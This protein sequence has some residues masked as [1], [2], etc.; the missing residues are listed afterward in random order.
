MSSMC[1]ESL[2]DLEHGMFYLFIFYSTL[3]VIQ[4]VRLL[5]GENQNNVTSFLVHVPRTDVSFQTNR[6]AVVTDR[7]FSHVHTHPPP[8]PTPLG[9][10]VLGLQAAA[11]TPFC[12]P[13]CR[14]RRKSVTHPSTLIQPGI[15]N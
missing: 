3:A 1:Y 6:S 4:T 13:C 5:A 11:R 2:G 10:G 8:T 7:L 12:S 9:R 14:S 15:Y